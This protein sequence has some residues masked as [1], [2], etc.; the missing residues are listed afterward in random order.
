MTA[1]WLTRRGAAGRAA[2]Y[3]WGNLVLFAASP[4]MTQSTQRMMRLQ[5]M[6]ALSKAGRQHR[7]LRARGRRELGRWT[8]SSS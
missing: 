6:L 5:M 7:R 8:S 3:A 4:L 1:S 2:V